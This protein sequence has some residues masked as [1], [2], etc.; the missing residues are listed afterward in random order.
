MKKRRAEEKVAFA[1]KQAETD[2]S[3]V[4]VTQ[5]MDFGAQVLQLQ[6]GVRRAGRRR[7]AASKAARGGEP[8]A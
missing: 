5:Q 8:Q 2:T 3:V 4:E 1:L 6:E 7:A